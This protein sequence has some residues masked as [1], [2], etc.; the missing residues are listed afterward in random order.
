MRFC[1][2]IECTSSREGIERT[3]LSDD[4]MHTCNSNYLCEIADTATPKKGK[5]LINK[6]RYLNTK[7][8]YELIRYSTEKTLR[9]YCWK[10]L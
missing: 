3:E 8:Q 9:Y 7:L 2:I 6:S 1:Y 5:Y 4:S 10:L